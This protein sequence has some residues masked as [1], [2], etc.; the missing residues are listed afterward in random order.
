MSIDFLIDA[1]NYKKLVQQIK[2]DFQEL[3]I[4]ENGL[5]SNHLVWFDSNK[6]KH[7]TAKL[8]KK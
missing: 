3:Y 8:R 6:N 7:Y 1:K 4:T 5:T 2:Y